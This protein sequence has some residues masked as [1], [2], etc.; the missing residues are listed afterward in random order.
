[1]RAR[2]VDAGIFCTIKRRGPRFEC[3]YHLS[4]RAIEYLPGQRLKYAVFERKFD[5]EVDKHPALPVASEMPEVVQML[6][7]SV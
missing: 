6:Q 5:F 1:M 4:K 7:R 3:A 2:T